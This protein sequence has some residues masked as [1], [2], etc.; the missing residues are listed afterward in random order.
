MP[1]RHRCAQH[2]PV[3]R[4]S[5][6]WTRA[7][8]RNSEKITAYFCFV[9]RGVPEPLAFPLEFVARRPPAGFWY[10]K[11]IPELFP[12]VAPVDVPGDFATAL[13][14]GTVLEFFVPPDLVFLPRSRRSSSA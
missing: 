14:A 4:Q 13:L 7:A 12:L 1:H 8:S 10:L 11:S 5:T 6:F 9:T 2:E 3:G